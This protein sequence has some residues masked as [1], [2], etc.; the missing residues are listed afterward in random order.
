[1]YN[2]GNNFLSYFN[3]TCP[4]LMLSKSSLYCT[5]SWSVDLEVEKLI[6]NNVV[7]VIYKYNKRFTMN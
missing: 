6:I 2:V 4:P 3:T 1:M 7:E 5:L